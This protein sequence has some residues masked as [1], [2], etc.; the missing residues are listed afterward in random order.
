MIIVNLQH[1]NTQIEMIILHRNPDLDF[2]YKIFF[3]YPNHQFP[4][5]KINK[6]VFEDYKFLPYNNNVRPQISVN[7][8]YQT[9]SE[10]KINFKIPPRKLKTGPLNCNKSLKLDL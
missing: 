5:S 7:G 10:Y 1:T 8:I 6:Y 4:Y 2:C 3:I 9:K